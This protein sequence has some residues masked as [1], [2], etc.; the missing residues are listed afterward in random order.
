MIGGKGQDI[1]DGGDGI[2]TLFGENGDDRLT[3]GSGDDILTGGKG[4]DFLDGGLGADILEGGKRDDIFV[5]RSGDGT[6]TILDF[7]LGGDRFGLADGLQ[8][9][10]LSFSGQTILAGDEVLTNLNGVN[11][12][13]LTAS[14]FS[15]I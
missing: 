12:E 8:F 11:T 3:G 9:E 15:I 6:D 4:N 14:D 10:N 1:L 2:D 5:L 13:E 7:K